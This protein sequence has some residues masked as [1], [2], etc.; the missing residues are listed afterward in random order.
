MEFKDIL[1]LLPRDAHIKVNVI[2]IEVEKE[3]GKFGSFVSYNGLVEDL[4]YGYFLDYNK[5]KLN[6]I[7]SEINNNKSYIVIYLEKEAK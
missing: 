3:R 1:N 5:L 6:T 7:N 4:T 2:D